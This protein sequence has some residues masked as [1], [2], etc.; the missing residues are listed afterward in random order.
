MEKTKETFF[1]EGA[2]IFVEGDEDV[3]EIYIVDSGAIELKSKN[4]LLSI[5]VL[6]SSYR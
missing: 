4:Q 6:M 2:Y 3:D 1:K 5:L